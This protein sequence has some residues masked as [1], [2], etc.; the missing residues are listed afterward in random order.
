MDTS[1]IPAIASSIAAA[2]SAIAAYLSFRL[3]RSG[4]MFNALA[5]IFEVLNDNAHRNARI[6]LYVAAKNYYEFRKT[7]DPTQLEECRR[8]LKQLGAN[9]EPEI[10]I[11]ESANIVLSDFEYLG[12][13]VKNGLIGEQE[14]IKKYWNTIIS[15]Y[16]V[17]IEDREKI[18]QYPDFKFLYSKATPY[19]NRQE[20]LEKDLYSNQV[21]DSVQ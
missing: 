14:I 1:D 12:A 3:N 10:I 17:L 11:P 6:R 16:E 2:A 19:R 9:K 21:S 18:D 4:Y 15:S 13:L 5:K 20:L 7:N 8:R